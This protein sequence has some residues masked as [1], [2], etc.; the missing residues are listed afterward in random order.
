MVFIRHFQKEMSDHKNK[1]TILG[2]GRGLEGHHIQP[3]ILPMARSIFREF[4]M[5]LNLSSCSFHSLVPIPAF[6]D[7]S[8]FAF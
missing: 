4:C 5:E 3:S 8:R 6:G 2:I 7:I 1:N